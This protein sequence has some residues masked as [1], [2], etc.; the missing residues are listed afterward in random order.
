M[1]D[2]LTSIGQDIQ[3]GVCPQ[4]VAKV[5]AVWSVWANF[6]STYNWPP[7][8]TGI[9]DPVP[10]ILLF[11]KKWRDG[12]IAPR[13]KSVRARTAEDAMRQVG[14]AFSLLGK[15]DPRHSRHAPAQL[16]FRYSR[17]ISFWKNQ[18]PGA[19][20]R[21]PLPRALLRKATEFSSRNDASPANKALNRLM[22]LGFFFL[23]RP[24]EYLYKPTAL[25]PFLLQQVFLRIGDVEYRGDTIPLHLLQS[26]HL[27]FAGLQ[28]EK[29]KNGV[30]DKKLDLERPSQNPTRSSFSP[31]W[32]STCD[33]SRRRRG[34]PPSTPTTTNMVPPAPSLTA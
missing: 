26:S 5:D 1:L 12:T 4:R 25:H 33:N 19:K 30:P 15:L 13:R 6:C 9:P 31:D 29:Q 3:R 7:D 34:Q 24:G 32:S 20:R 27:T 8:L 2:D 16:D 21:R 18:D 11:G 14:Q 10:A 22:W 28:F 23:L 17:L